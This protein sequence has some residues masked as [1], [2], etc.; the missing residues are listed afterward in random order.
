MKKQSRK[1][2]KLGRRQ[3][4]KNERRKL[5]RTFERSGMT[6][7][8]FSKVNGIYSTTLS[9]WIRSFGRNRKKDV[10]VEFAEV[11]LPAVKPEISAKLVYPDG[12]VLHLKN[13]TGISVDI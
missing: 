12:R 1:T 8:A 5:V 3:Y 7:S 11:D 10:P 2:D 13:K 9:G 4:S 6:Q